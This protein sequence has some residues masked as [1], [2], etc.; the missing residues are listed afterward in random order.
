[1]EDN[2]TPVEI[3]L[4]RGQAFIRTS[5]RLLK[6]K[7]TEKVAEIASKLVS[8]FVILMLL[9]F[10]FINLNIGIALFI[11][12]VLGKIWLG[13]FIIAGF[14]GLCGFIVYLFRNRWIKRAVSNS[15]IQILLKDEQFN[16]NTL[17]D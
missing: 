4:E 3:L 9:V 7:G 10:L 5:L 6:L 8:G 11:G 16:E 13:F 14:Y 17:S 1:M 12:D 15:V 2:K